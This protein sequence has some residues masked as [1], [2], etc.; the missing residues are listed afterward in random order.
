MVRPFACYYD[1]G[2]YKYQG[3]IYWILLNGGH[4]VAELQIQLL[5]NW[6]L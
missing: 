1:I 5:Y 6:I 3:N 4:R 2:L